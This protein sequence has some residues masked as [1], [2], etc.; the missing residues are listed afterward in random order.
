MTDDTAGTLVDRLG[1]SWGSSFRDIFLI[2]ASI[3]IAFGL[4]AW[5]DGQRTL[6]VE[7]AALSSV[8]GLLNELGEPGD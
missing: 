8:Q 2:V 1:R 7:R 6:D 3:L 4:E 5:W